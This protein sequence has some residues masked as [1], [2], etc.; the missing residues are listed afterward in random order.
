[1]KGLSPLDWYFRGTR[2]FVAPV[3]PPP[4]RRVNG[5]QEKIHKY[6]YRHT[7]YT[8][9]VTLTLV[10]QVSQVLYFTVFYCVIL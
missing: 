7:M 2:A 1:M 10:T 6:I 5:V 4:L 3:A 9:E 8:W